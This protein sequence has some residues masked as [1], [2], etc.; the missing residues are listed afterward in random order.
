MLLRM[1]VPETTDR[2]LL[3]LLVENIHWGPRNWYRNTRMAKELRRL[4]SEVNTL[5]NVQ[6]RIKGDVDDL[7]DE[8][9]QGTPPAVMDDK[10][11]QYDEVKHTVRTF[12][13]VSRYR[14]SFYILCIKVKTFAKVCPSHLLMLIWFLFQLPWASD[15]AVEEFFLRDNDLPTRIDALRQ[16]VFNRSRTAKERVNFVNRILSQLMTDR[17]AVLKSYGQSK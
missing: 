8:K 4:T 17:Y 9:H 7:K 6:V 1:L 5:Q 2:A 11:P 12:A 3:E 14:K 16:I 10:A 13:I 15:R